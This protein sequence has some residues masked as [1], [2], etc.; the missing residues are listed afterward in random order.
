M[1]IL[2]VV[3]EISRMYYI[4]FCFT[5]LLVCFS[6]FLLP[7]TYRFGLLPDLKTDYKY[8]TDF[9]TGLKLHIKKKKILKIIEKGP[10]QRIDAL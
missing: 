10:H 8:E 6:S 9:T 2:S 3:N 1:E 7:G 5:A 4:L